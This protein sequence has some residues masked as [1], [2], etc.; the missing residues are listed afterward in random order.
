MDK[1]NFAESMWEMG[2]WKQGGGWGDS[3]KWVV[4]NVK[5]TAIIGFGAWLDMGGEKEG[6][7]KYDLHSD[8]CNWV[9]D[10]VVC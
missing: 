10:G 7:V 4:S 9:D 8:L 1:D 5:K 3:E 2:Y 6:G